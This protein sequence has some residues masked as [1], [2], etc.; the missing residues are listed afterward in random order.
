MEDLDLEDLHKECNIE[1]QCERGHECYGD[2][3]KGKWKSGDNLDVI[4]KIRYYRKR[5]EWN[6]SLL[7]ELSRHP[8]IITLYGI[9]CSS[10]PTRRY[11]HYIF[12]CSY[13]A[14]L[15]NLFCPQGLGGKSEDQREY[16][17]TYDDCLRW[18][19]NIGEGMNH[20]HSNEILHCNLTSACV[21]I[22]NRDIAVLS[23]LSSACHVDKVNEVD[24]AGTARWRAPELMTLHCIV[25]KESD[26]YSYG[27]V[28]Y[29]LIYKKLPFIDERSIGADFKVSQCK[30]PD[31][32]LE[33]KTPQYVK[34]LMESCWNHD[35]QK[36]PNF[37][38]I[39]LVFDC[40][41]FPLPSKF[42]M[43][44]KNTCV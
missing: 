33:V 7:L 2:V 10:P 41:K 6:N 20:L 26:V 16:N 34:N 24:V 28:L 13:V 11:L 30:R 4:I 38:E 32:E 44:C 17:F 36:R 23:D 37:H 12:P 40:Q 43:T 8:N 27:I 42:F 5:N 18:A 21:W 31:L 3:Y 35:I 9:V 15:H 25:T 1:C 29:E 14:C 39:T 19:Q 22:N